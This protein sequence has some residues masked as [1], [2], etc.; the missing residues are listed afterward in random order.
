VRVD[1]EK[2]TAPLLPVAV[3]MEELASVADAFNVVAANAV[4]V[5]TAVRSAAGPPTS[6]SSRNGIMGIALCILF[7][8][9]FRYIR[10][11]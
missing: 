8:F 9:H 7:F 11:G 5:D 10:H 6:R 3:T 1:L 2:I 4:T